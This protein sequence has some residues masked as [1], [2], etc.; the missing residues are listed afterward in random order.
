MSNKITKNAAILAAAVVFTSFTACG[1]SSDAQ[2]DHQSVETY[3]DID[4]GELK[5]VQIYNFPEESMFEI[6]HGVKYGMT[7]EDVKNIEGTPSEEGPFLLKF[8]TSIN[9]YQAVLSYHFFFFEP[10]DEWTQYQ[11]VTGA[12]FT[13]SLEGLSDAQIYNEYR[14][15]RKTYMEIYGEPDTSVVF[16]INNPD[17]IMDGYPDI[18]GDINFNGDPFMRDEFSVQ[19]GL[20]IVMSYSNIDDNSK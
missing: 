12:M 8:N 2:Q 1:G 14:D 7:K 9:N 18:D 10:G 13:I 20:E 4:T 11:N 15:I 5:E 3:K 6:L 16:A 19:E 17:L